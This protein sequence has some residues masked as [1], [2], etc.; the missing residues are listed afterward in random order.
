MAKLTKD[1]FGVVDGEV[2]PKIIPAGE[3]CPPE[4]EAAAREIGALEGKAI[5]GAPENKGA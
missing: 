1:I 5:K 2:Y 3:E 4:L